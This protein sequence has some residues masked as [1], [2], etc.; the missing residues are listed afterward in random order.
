MKKNTDLHLDIVRDNLR[1]RV[2]EYDS[3]ADLLQDI[4]KA[5]FW[6]G[7]EADPFGDGDDFTMFDI[8]GAF[9]AACKL[10]NYV[11]YSR[12]YIATARESITTAGYV[13]VKQEGDF[14]HVCLCKPVGM[15]ESM[16]EGRCLIIETRV[17]KSGKIIATCL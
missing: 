17:S 13:I 8:W 5:V 4:S 3:A 6:A 1:D 10:D 2:G 7:A 12:E 14:I 16:Y 11:D 9:A 15:Y